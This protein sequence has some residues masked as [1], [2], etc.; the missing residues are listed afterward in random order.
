M[1]DND[2]I[3]TYLEKIR[4]NAAQYG[5]LH[6]ERHG[7]LDSSLKY[8]KVPVLVL[9]ALSS[10][11]SLSQE[12]I[13]QGTITIMN[14]T[15]GLI[16]SVIVSLELFFGVSR[17]LGRSETVSKDFYNLATEIKKQLVL[18]KGKSR[19]D[20]LP[21]VESAYSQYT[22]LVTNSSVID[23]SE[24]DDRLLDS[25]IEL[26]APKVRPRRTS[27]LSILNFSR[28]Y[29]DDSIS[30]PSTPRDSPS[31]LTSLNKKKTGGLDISPMG[32]LQNGIKMSFDT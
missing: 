2:P 22:A 12:F 10:A 17:E 11:V 5:K 9:S 23:L 6:R 20:I 14:T 8:Y 31:Y 30:K 18:L 25:E 3:L 16:C 1:E 4:S 19:M 26:E 15:L 13:P 29:D 27:M 28:R 7:Q 24:I 32:E 21:Y